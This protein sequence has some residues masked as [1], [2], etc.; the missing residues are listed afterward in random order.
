MSSSQTQPPTQRERIVT[1]RSRK[2]HTS[3]LLFKD[4][5][6]D[7]AQM[8][9]CPLTA[10]QIQC[11]STPHHPLSGG[12]PGPAW[13]AQEVKA[14]AAEAMLSCLQEPGS[15][16]PGG[17]K[18]GFLQSPHSSLP[19]AEMR[20]RT[21]SQEQGVLATALLLGGRVAY[22]AHPRPG[23]G[24][25]LY[26]F[27]SVTWSEQLPLTRLTFLICGRGLT[28]VPLPYVTMSIQPEC[29][30]GSQQRWARHQHR[31]PLLGLPSNRVAKVPGP[32]L[33]ALHA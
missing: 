17:T 4:K 31:A 26:C 22:G 33:G 13:R 8:E 25:W 3:S 9:P 23:F 7:T 21:R 11:L 10:P 27:P 30:W 24:C 28:T 12:G 6:L 16:G 5:T 14:G 2:L 32:G 20:P 18:G 1:G 15:R 19:P 29:R